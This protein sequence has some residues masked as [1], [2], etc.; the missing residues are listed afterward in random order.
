MWVSLGKSKVVKHVYNGMDRGH[1]GH[2]TDRAYI[3]IHK[4]VSLVNA[5]LQKGSGQSK[6]W[7]G[8][9]R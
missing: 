4:A 9:I 5:H 7:G 8:S 6:E 1:T 3:C 2:N